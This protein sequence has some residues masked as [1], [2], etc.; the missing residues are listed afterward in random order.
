ME[1]K[2]LNSKNNFINE[3]KT[4]SGVTNLSHQLRKANMAY[5]AKT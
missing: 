4:V 5:V 3:K 2:R 1:G